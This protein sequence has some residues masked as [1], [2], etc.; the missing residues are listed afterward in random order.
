MLS[1]VKVKFCKVV[2]LESQNKAK[3]SSRIINSIH[4]SDSF[5]REDTS[6]GT[7]RLRGQ[8]EIL[9]QTR[10]TVKNKIIVIQASIGSPRKNKKLCA[11]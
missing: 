9:V 4:A 7:T 11:M 6:I 1:T 10:E 3:T 2:K 5:S 8:A